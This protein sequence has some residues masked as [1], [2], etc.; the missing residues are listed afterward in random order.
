LNSRGF[1]PMIRIGTAVTHKAER[2]AAHLWFD[3]FHFNT[4]S[5][6]L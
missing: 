3:E 6:E 2:P 5:T 1:D 4:C